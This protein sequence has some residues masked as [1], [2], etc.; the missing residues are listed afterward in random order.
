M[1]D[2][3]IQKDSMRFRFNLER[4]GYLFAYE[5]SKTLAY[6]EQEVQTPWVFPVARSWK[7]R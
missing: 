4:L 2:V 1:R 7:I 3:N 5:I 6:R